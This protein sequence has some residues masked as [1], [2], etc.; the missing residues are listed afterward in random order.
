MVIK[1]T[2]TRASMQRPTIESVKR[3]LFTDDDNDASVLQGPAKRLQYDND[4]KT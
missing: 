3:K 2:A 1:Y 4:A